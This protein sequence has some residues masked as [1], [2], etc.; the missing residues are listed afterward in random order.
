M[1]KDYDI[2]ILCAGKKKQFKHPKNIS[3]VK[4]ND[5]FTILQRQIDIIDSKFE[6]SR[7]ILVSGYDDRSFRKIRYFGDNS[8][9]IYKNRSYVRHNSIVSLKLGLKKSRAEKIIV[10]YND[11]VFEKNIFDALPEQSTIFTNENKRDNICVSVL[12][13]QVVNLFWDLGDEWSEIFS[14][15][16]ADNINLLKIGVEECHDN[17]FVFE[18]INRAIGRGLS[19]VPYKH[20]GRVMDIDKKSEIKLTDDF[21]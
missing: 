12:E 9:S 14:V 18:G 5:Q 16:G 13:G 3:F 8:I 1:Y 10:M 20:G 21:E 11:L 15:C 6:D 2:I 19:F 4:L 7:I 17:Q